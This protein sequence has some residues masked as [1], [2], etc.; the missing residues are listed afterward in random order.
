VAGASDAAGEVVAGALG[1]GADGAV[2]LALSLAAG[3]DATGE[4]WAASCA[5]AAAS[6]AIVNA[7]AAQ[8]SLEEFKSREER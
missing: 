1:A 6:P 8:A 3:G 2:G 4:G 5:D 7:T